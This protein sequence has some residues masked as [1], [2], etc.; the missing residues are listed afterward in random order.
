MW[1]PNIMC[2]Y[3]NVIKYHLSVDDLQ[4]YD[5]IPIIE[6]R[7]QTKLPNC[8]REEINKKIPLEELFVL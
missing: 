6:S 3:L 4:M 2:G 1:P 5:E 7:I 8:F